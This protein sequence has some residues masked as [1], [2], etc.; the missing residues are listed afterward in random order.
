M[1][2]SAG[3]NG[4]PSRFELAELNQNLNY[5]STFYNVEIT[6]E[7]GLFSVWLEKGKDDPAIATRVRHYKNRPAEELYDVE[8]DPYE[9]NNLAD[10]PAYA[11]VKEELRKELH[12]WM[13]QQGD[14]GNATELRANE[15]QGKSGNTTWAPY[16]PNH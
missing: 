3:G 11:D 13:R 5:E 16:D 14:E 6:N 10:D 7:S 12:R 2:A 15:R 1:C 9:L 4:S 8:Q